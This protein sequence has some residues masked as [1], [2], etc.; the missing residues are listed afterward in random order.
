MYS[1]S[2]LSIEFAKKQQTFSLFKGI[3]F[4]STIA[5]LSLYFD[6][7]LNRLNSKKQLQWRSILQTQSISFRKTIKR[8]LII[9]FMI[10]SFFIGH[11]DVVMMFVFGPNSITVL[12]IILLSGIPLFSRCIYLFFACN[13]KCYQFVW[14]KINYF[15]WAV[16]WHPC[17]TSRIFYVC[18]SS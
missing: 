2:R 8:N 1:C 4:L 7:L 15:G 5:K 18:M 9:L 17:L 14:L 16:S 10:Q 11:F 6:F 12:F 13:L 3:I